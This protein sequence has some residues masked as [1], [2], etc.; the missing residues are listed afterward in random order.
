MSLVFA[1]DF[2][3]VVHDYKNP[4]QGKRMGKPIHGANEALRKLKAR[5]HRIIIFSTWGDEKGKKTIE[6]F[7]RF[8]GLLFDDITNTKPQADYYI[9]DKGVRFTSWDDF[10]NLI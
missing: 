6:D 3:G 4:I 10:F 8:Y 5:G 9:D 7:M 1:L 2:D